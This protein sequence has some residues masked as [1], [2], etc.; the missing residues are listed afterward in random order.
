MVDALRARL[1]A[2]SEIDVITT[3]PNR[4]H[5]FIVNA[6]NVEQD[7][8]VSIFR[9][10]L[11]AHKSGLI[12][13]SKAFLTF[14]RGALSRADGRQYDLVFATSSRLMTAVLG[15]L[16]A[17]RH[18]AKLYLDIRDI[19][20]DTI[21]DV[22]PR[23]IAW[24]VKP[25]LS[26]LEKW[27]VN[28]ADK[29]NLVSRGFSQ[30]F[31]ARYPQQRFSYYTNGV[32]NEFMVAPTPPAA[33]ATDED[34]PVTVVYA[35]NIGEGQGLHA[36]IPALAKSM[37]SHTHFKVIGDGGRKHALEVAITASGVTNVE[38]LEPL[39]RADLLR[40]Y[41]AADVLFLHLNDHEAFK[42]VLPSKLFEYAALG[43]PVWA[44]VGG[45]AAEFVTSEICNSAVFHPCDVPGAVRA[46]GEL[47]IRDIPRPDFI[48]KYA[49]SNISREMT[50]DILAVAS[51]R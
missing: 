15:A 29:V 5:S 32:D 43:K 26:A 27:T 28:R 2:G 12:D 33:A 25:A 47:K 42:K 3:L 19:F 50:E 1:P 24:A 22:L 6:S 20:V 16:L 48:A 44:G 46:F 10:A 39:G 30:Y 8:D 40:E 23:G 45:Y 7:S 35:G 13:Q 31:G 37:G 34:R 11:P 14:S 49:R 41:R 51:E 4:Y 36:V 38:L 9:I 18:R 21:G 17:R